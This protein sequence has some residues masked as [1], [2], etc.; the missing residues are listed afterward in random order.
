MLEATRTKAEIDNR[1]VIV[2]F[3]NENFRGKNG[4]PVK[5]SNYDVQTFELQNEHMDASFFYYVWLVNSVQMSE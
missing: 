3:G 4:G 5:V 1:R 2:V